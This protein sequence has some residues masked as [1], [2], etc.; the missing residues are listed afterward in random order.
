MPKRKPKQATKRA[1]D[2]ACLTC[3]GQGSY[4]YTC[5]EVEDSCIC[6]PDDMNIG[7]CED[8]QGE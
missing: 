3:R 6:E 5:G 4:C 7:D 2:E 1:P 8:C